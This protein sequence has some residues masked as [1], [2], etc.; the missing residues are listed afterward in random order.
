MATINSVN[1]TLTTASGTVNFLG[2]ASPVI[3]SGDCGDATTLKIP[4]GTSPTLSNAGE[5]A[6][7]TSIASF[8][9]MLKYRDSSQTLLGVSIPTAD[10]AS[11]T[12]GY[13]I[14][15]SSASSKLTLIAQSGGSSKIVGYTSATSTSD[16]TTTSTSDVDTSLT[17][18]YTPTNSSNLLLI[19]VYGAGFAEATTTTRDRSSIYTIRRTSGTPADLA[20]I[21][22]GRVSSVN[23]SATAPT[24]YNVSFYAQETAG[25]T[26][27]HTYILR[28]RCRSTNETTSFTGTTCAAFIIVMEML[29]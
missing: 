19:Y 28:H 20:V 23:S 17:V 25:S 14:G 3:T 4:S 16:D 27:S 5:I 29:V 1:N 11:P 8:N 24:Y 26:S 9:G 13:I 15:Y 7:D 10:L 22:C 6:V 12:N 2:S 18:S 21:P